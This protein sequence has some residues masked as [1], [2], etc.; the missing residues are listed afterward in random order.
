VSF[1][2]Q[3]DLLAASTLRTLPLLLAGSSPILQEIGQR[4][5]A[6][7]ARSATLTSQVAI[8]ALARRDYARAAAL[9]DAAAAPGEPEAINARLY[10]ALALLM[11][12]KGAE[13][14]AII[15]AVGSAPALSPAEQRDLRWLRVMLETP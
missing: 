2:D 15:A 12:E 6:R 14:R 13:A 7:G 8:G 4:A 10:Q 3:R 11:A 5:W 1:E 9:F